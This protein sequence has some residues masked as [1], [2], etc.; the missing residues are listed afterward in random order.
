M[1]E[2]ISSLD[3]RHW[4]GKFYGGSA[5][6]MCGLWMGGDTTRGPATVASWPQSGLRICWVDISEWPQGQN[7][8]EL[9][10]REPSALLSVLRLCFYIWVG[11]TPSETFNEMQVRV[12]TSLSRVGTWDP[13]PPWQCTSHPSFTDWLQKTTISNCISM[14]VMWLRS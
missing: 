4:P 13:Q 8:K 10:L 7:T 3:T 11:F 1:R 12:V 14:G 6:L 2:W 5:G 9:R